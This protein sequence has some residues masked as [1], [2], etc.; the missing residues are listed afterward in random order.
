MNIRRFLLF[1]LLIPCLST[2]TVYGNGHNLCGKYKPSGDKNAD[3]FLVQILV[4]MSMSA[5]SIQTHLE[6]QI[7]GACVSEVAFKHEYNRYRLANTMH[8]KNL[9]DT[10]FDKNEK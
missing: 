3:K 6:Y 9:A 1:V 7:A 5:S 4:H 10:T 2:N 8:Q